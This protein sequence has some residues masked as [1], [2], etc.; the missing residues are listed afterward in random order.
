[1]RP[2]RPGA[3]GRGC[4]RRRGLLRDGRSFPARHPAGGGGPAGV[5]GGPARWGAV[6]RSHR[7]P[8]LR[9]A[10]P[11]RCRTGTADGDGETTARPAV[12]RSATAVVP[13][14]TRRCVRHLHRP[15]RVGV[16]RGRRHRRPARRGTR[17]GRPARGAA[18]DLHRGGRD[19]VAAGPGHLGPALGTPRAPGERGAART[20]VAGAGVGDLRPRRGDS[21]PVVGGAYR[22]RGVP[23]GAV[24]APHRGGWLVDAAA[25]ARHRLRL[26]GA[27]RRR[28]P[29]VGTV[30][31]PVRGLHGL[32]TRRAW[33]R[34]VPG[35]RRVRPTGV[36][37][38]RAGRGSRGNSPAR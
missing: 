8:P 16:L 10:R 3:G 15:V 23:P 25:D 29:R 21:P 26:R 13:A 5:R 6:R 11:R 31:R 35:E 7:G 18:H 14:R 37:A 32:A 38:G 17:R 4:R 28:D 19:T 20:A 24:G 33:L 27:P 34:D 12:L 22:R 36:L 2:V 30:A 1:M 9:A